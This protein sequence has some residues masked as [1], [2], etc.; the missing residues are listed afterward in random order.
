M[1][2]SARGFTVIELIIVISLIG[3]LAAVGASRLG[4]N[5]E[6]KARAF[7][8]DMGQVLSAAQRM[9]VA[10]RRTV[11]AQLVVNPGSLKLCF[12]AACTQPVAAA[13]GDVT[14]LRAP[15]GMALQTSSTAFN[16]NSIGRP[17]L[18]TPLTLSLIAADGT[19]LLMGVTLQAE[20]GYV[21]T[22]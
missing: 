16:F 10:Q 3:I 18:A 15:T 5:D 7:V 12:D 2:K 22:F 20:T 1:K 4:G 6:L 21:A 19:A 9:A 13:P 17:S 8:N 11:Y 14:E